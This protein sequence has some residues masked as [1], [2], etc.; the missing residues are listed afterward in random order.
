V[1]AVTA[2]TGAPS[3]ASRSSDAGS[4]VDIAAR[5]RLTALFFGSPIRSRPHDVA[6]AAREVDALSECTSKRSVRSERDEVRCCDDGKRVDSSTVRMTVSGLTTT[7]AGDDAT[8][9]C[10]ESVDHRARKI[11]AST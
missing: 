6:G 1:H 8:Q 10:R 7:D 4:C 3:S 5:H 2:G 9:G 11:T